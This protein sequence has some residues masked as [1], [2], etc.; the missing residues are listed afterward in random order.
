MLCRLLVIERTDAIRQKLRD[1]LSENHEIHVLESGA[2][3]RESIE[4]VQPALILLDFH[5]REDSAVEICR[6]I[7]HELASRPIQLLVLGEGLNET[8]RLQMFAVGADDVIDKSIGWLELTAKIDVFIRLHSALMRAT[9]AERKL[10][11]YSREL[12]RIV[13]N[14][15]MAIQ[16]TQDIAVFAL[17]KLADSRDTETGEH[18]VRMRAYSQMIAEQLRISGPYQDAIDDSFLQD[19]FRSSPLHDI[20]KVGISDAIL[21]KP[22]SLTAEEFNAMK[23]HVRIGAETLQEAAKSSSSGSFFHMAAEIARYHHE[24]WDGCGYLEGLKGVEI[25]LAARIVSVADV[26]DALSSKRVYKDAICLDEARAMI[27]EASGTQFD[28][29]IVTAFEETFDKLKVLSAEQHSIVR[30]LSAAQGHTT[31][32]HWGKHQAV[33]ELSGESAVVI[34]DGSPSIGLITA[35]LQSVGMKVRV[36]GEYISAQQ[37]IREDCP[38]VVISDW[39]K[40]QASAE[41]FCRWIREERLPRYVFTMVL[42]EQGV[43][44]DPT[45]AYRL[46]IDDV[47]SHSIGREELL[48]RINSAGRVI[49]LENHLRTIE[50]NDPLTGLATLRYLNDQLK[51]EWVRSRNYHL[52]MSCVVIDIDDFSEINRQYGV[53]VGDKVLQKLAKTIA[54]QGRQIDYLCRLDSDR[55]LL[56]LPECAE[57][58]AYR[59]AMRIEMLVNKMGVEADG[60]SIYCSVSMGIAQRNNDVPK[61]EALI[62][63]AEIALKAAKSAGKRRIV[64]LGNCEESDGILAS[65]DQV[66]ECMEHLTASEIMTS[67]ILTIAQSDTI[68][69]ATRLLIEEGVNSAPV[70]D[71]QGYLVG[72]ISEKDLM[73][74]FRQPEAG[75]MQ[76]SEMIRSEA[77]CFEESDPAIHV[78]E[79]L[80]QAAIRRVIVVKDER[81]TG[82]ISR[83]NCLRWIHQ[84]DVEMGLGDPT[85]LADVIDS[86]ILETATLSQ[87]R[88]II[89]GMDH[90]GTANSADRLNF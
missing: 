41:I 27:C 40:G 69:V 60:E 4:Q 22:G 11:G 89:N 23:Q 3:I 56:V 64:C 84:L 25:P 58:N 10:E 33:P 18:L 61:L 77:V 63:N 6:T 53:E 67:P 30:F 13:E 57:I 9:T 51:R 45:Q 31:N 5:L 7:R 36:C 81:P 8:Q 14:R 82:V 62:D 37:L 24:H 74:A 28:P 88:N 21:L 68:S 55:L 80:S 38:M 66:R 26:F 50:R 2:S 52:P 90:S 16:E 1:V 79:Y 19:L 78:Y 44:K 85:M 87:I 15:S 20:G 75:D 35:W 59:L 17:A 12:E 47:I 49:E 71:Q 34:N 73:Q 54:V 72:V 83:G 86:G 29:A 43:L 39:G 32:Y 46:G 76:V 70:V 42:A 65:D 48:A